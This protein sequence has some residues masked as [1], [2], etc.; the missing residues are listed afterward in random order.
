LYKYQKIYVLG[1]GAVGCF[2]GGM[3]AR[4]QKSVTLIA[5]PE[6]AEAINESGLEMDCKS[7]R[8]VVHINASSD[9][10]R[11]SDADLILL[12]VKSPD[13]EKVIREI[14]PIL[15][16]HTVI[17]SLQNGVANA[18][19]A[20]QIVPNPVYAAVV[21]VAAGMIGHRT[22]KHHG[23]GELY[24]GGLQKT[25]REDAGRLRGICELF[26]S[27]DIPCVVAENLKKDMWLKFLVNC[28]YNAI[29]GIGQIA[30][31]EMVQVPE[32][33]RQIENLTQEFVAIAAKEGVVISESEAREANALIASTMV[34][35]RSSTAQDLA[36]GKKTEIDF[37]NGYIVDLGKKHGIPVPYNESIYALVKMLERF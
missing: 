8:E 32:I 21:Y 37:L 3:L 25:G 30:Y 19:I 4:A 35:Q 20:S 36:K 7:F 28:S 1:A 10:N 18:D 27:S 9:L 31:G 6:R 16:S 13:T 22:M 26:S 17:L 2:F 12:S 23:R 15:S 33:V 34:T 24:I 5:R 29:S 11:L 14:A